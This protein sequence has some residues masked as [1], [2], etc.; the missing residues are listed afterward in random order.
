M[1]FHAENKII[2]VESPVDTS[3]SGSA[4]YHKEL[5]VLSLKTSEILKNINIFQN[6]DSHGPKQTNKQNISQETA[7]RSSRLSRVQ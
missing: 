3:V 2:S 1:S 5:E 7:G 6:C 4:V